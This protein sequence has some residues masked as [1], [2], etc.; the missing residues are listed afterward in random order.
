MQRLGA[1]K[2]MLE[3]AKRHPEAYPAVVR[4]LQLREYAATHPAFLSALEAIVEPLRQGNTAIK[5]AT[6]AMVASVGAVRKIAVPLR[7]VMNAICAEHQAQLAAIIAEEQSRTAA[8]LAQLVADLR[9][10]EAKADRVWEKQF[11]CPRP[12][13]V[14]DWQRLA[15]RAGLSADTVLK[16]AWTPGDMLPIIEGYFQHLRDQQAVKT[17]PIIPETTDWSRCMSLTD[18]AI[19]LFNDATMW[20]KVR[21]AYGEHM[22]KV[23]RKTW[24]IRLDKLG[25]TERENMKKR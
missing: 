11:P 12:K 21:S 15:A 19:R 20:R 10:A 9:K 17:D 1:G 23:N 13:T 14:A 3:A 18:M 5:A 25:P 22:C 16:G 24:R 4:M 7:P 8:D 2:A 6:A